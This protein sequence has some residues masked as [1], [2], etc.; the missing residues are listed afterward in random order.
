MSLTN[1]MYIYIYTHWIY[2]YDLYKMNSI[3]QPFLIS[4]KE[5]NKTVGKGK[6]VTFNLEKNTIKLYYPKDKE[7]KKKYTVFHIA[8]ISIAIWILLVLSKRVI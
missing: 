7:D 6:R 8:C 4:L 1:R 5:F 2:C 3:P